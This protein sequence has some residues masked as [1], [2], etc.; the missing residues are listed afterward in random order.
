MAT[1]AP[2]KIRI[3]IVDDFAETRENIRKLLQFENDMEVVGGARSGAEALDMARETQPDVVL[4]DINMPDMDGISATKALLDDVPYAQIVIL[5]VNNEPDYM[6]RAML[7]G[8]RDFIAKPPSPDELISTIRLVSERARDQK[9]R[10]EKDKGR[11]EP[12]D[13]PGDEDFRRPS[14]PAGKAIAV[15]SAK[16]GVGVT[17]L[18]TNLA[19]GLHT[20]ETPAVL[21]DS[22]LQFG[23]VS[24]FLNLQVKNSIA[25]LSARAEELDNDVVDEV[26]MTHECGLR[27]LAAPQRP[28][29]ADD[30]H[31]DQVRKVL[32][33]LKRVFAYV[34][35]D[36]S[37]TMDDTTLAVLDVADLL[38]AVAT[39]D[40]PAI[41]DARLLFDLLNVLEFPAGHVLFVLNKMDRRTG[42]TA[43]AVAENLKHAVDG[44]IPYA[45]QTVTASV[46]R[47]VPLLL[48]DKSRPPA[49]NLLDLLGAIKHKLVAQ[50]KEEEEVKVAERP[51]AF[52]R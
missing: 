5:S 37:S 32:Q 1:S 27:V 24:V 36:T 11:K 33:F 40:I 30:V 20:E 12:P 42:I 17:T 43:E 29:M 28:E 18:A 2:E 7:A 15:Y 14:R 19:V 51:R 26:L 34:I 23:D 9:K 13:V 39:P 16:G 44:E 48:G 50:A 21:V 31:A 38:V 52:G 25:D 10:I 6:R 4:M 47:G 41:K 35:I 8:A 22:C 45:E 3:L 46:N 49:R